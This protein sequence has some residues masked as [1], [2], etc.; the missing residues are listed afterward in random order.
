MTATTGDR[1][2][3]A[4][5]AL[6]PA[7]RAR[8]AAFRFGMGPKQGTIER[9]SR[10]PNA[11]VEACL[12]EL[13][14][15]QAALIASDLPAEEDYQRCA[16]AGG[17]NLVSSAVRYKELG[18]RFSKHMEPEVGFVE[19]L[20]LFWANHFSIHQEKSVPV[21]ST[22]GHLERTVIRRHVLGS[23]PDMLK[24]V[25]AHPAMVGYLDN[26]HSRKGAVNENLAREILELY[27]IGTPKRFPGR[28]W[29]YTQADVESLARILTGWGINQD[30][31]ERAKTG[32]GRFGQFRFRQD[33]HDEASHTLL[34]QSFGA[35][36]QQKGL[37]ALEWLATHSFTA[38][39]I[40]YKLLLHFV[41]DDPPAAWVTALAQVFTSSKGD[42]LAVARAL[43]GME[44]AWAA[45]QRLRPPHLWVMA[46][47][48]A[49]GFGPEDFG[50]TQA[51]IENHWQTRLSALD[52]GVWSWLT[53]D[54]VPDGDADW[55]DPDAMRMR[56]L[57]ANQL[58]RDAE[59]RGRTLPQA[60]SLRQQ[61]LPGSRQMTALAGLQSSI[62]NRA[63]I[64]DLFLSSEFMTR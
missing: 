39:N 38:Q 59:T 12:A 20:V 19:R 13:A 60:A 24:E 37:D 25:I 49:L 57:A 7:A 56:L 63:S 47:A 3:G 22:V 15:P 52:N 1:F 26:Q 40:C 42:L 50:T 31:A 11:A 17:N 44:E 16:T 58:L 53:P 21:R 29:G 10:S 18:D 55:L 54:G 46:Q 33:W 4:A 43:I 32:G 35:A 2:R 62:H 9:L 36:G 61:L 6:R 48:R 45:P 64:A 41:R 5:R 8:V 51:S 23:F 14:N 30:F 34:G 28:T 27:T